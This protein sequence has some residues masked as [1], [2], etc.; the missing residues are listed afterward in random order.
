MLPA[1]EE[2]AW[3]LQDCSQF[4]QRLLIIFPCVLRAGL[5]IA[6]GP[7]KVQTVSLASSENL[8]DEEEGERG[9]WTTLKKVK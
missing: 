4:G 7:V 9:D 2:A 1:A 3:Q 8:L 5:P 6:E